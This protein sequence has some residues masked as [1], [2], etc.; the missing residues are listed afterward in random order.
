VI[1]YDA[2]KEFRR[3]P[4]NISAPKASP[5]SRRLVIGF[6]GAGSYAQGHILPKPYQARTHK[7]GRG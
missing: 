7:E 3:A 2:A 1:E 5:G 4:V 6:I